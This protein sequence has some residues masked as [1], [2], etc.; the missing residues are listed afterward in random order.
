MFECVQP[1]VALQ[2]Y[3]R[4]GLAVPGPHFTH[5]LQV[6]Q[7]KIERHEIFFFELWFFDLMMIATVE[8]HLLDAKDMFIIPHMSADGKE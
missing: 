4:K 7:K 1:H 3:E 8:L 5:E 2:V 6:K